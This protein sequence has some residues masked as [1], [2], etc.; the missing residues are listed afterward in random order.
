MV[1]WAYVIIFAKV[2]QD[3]LEDEDG[4]GAAKNSQRLTAKHAKDASGDAV[5]KKWFQDTLLAPGD[6]TEEA[7]EGD[8]LCNR[9]LK[10]H[11]STMWK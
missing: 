5:A 6:V 9:G 1:S 8:G 10:G 2:H 4:S 3:L 11:H 7:P